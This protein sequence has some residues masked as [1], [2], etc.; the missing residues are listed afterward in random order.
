MLLAALRWRSKLLI[1]TP[2]F[3]L[4]LFGMPAISNLLMSSLE[5]RFSYRSNNDCPRADA[6]FVFGG[7]LSLRSHQGGGIE[8]NEA[9]ERFYRAIDLYKAGRANVLVLSGGPETYPGGPDEGELL[10]KKQRSW[11]CPTAQSL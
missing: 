5:D 8:W 1:A 9:A 3:L 10:K 2:L 11:V 7:M 6:I 4:S